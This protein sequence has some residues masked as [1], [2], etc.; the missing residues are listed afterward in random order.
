MSERFRDCAMRFKQNQKVRDLRWQMEHDA[1][2]DTGT[3]WAQMLALPFMEGWPQG[4][5]F[6]VL[7]N[8]G[9]LVGR[10]P[11][12]A[13]FDYEDL[14]IHITEQQLKR[15]EVMS[16]ALAA[17]DA[18]EKA[19]LLGA[20]VEADVEPALL[21][22]RLMASLK[23]SHRQVYEALYPVSYTHLTLPTILLV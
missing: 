13:P 14:S 6:E 17:L 20:T 23:H 4:R 19:H 21:K 22:Q 9:N 15:G 16:T 1:P 7:D 10:H 11:D 18:E 5:F 2:L 12:T 8:D 3:A